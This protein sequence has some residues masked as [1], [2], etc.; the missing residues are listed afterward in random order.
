MEKKSVDFVLK[1]QEILAVENTA[2]EHWISLDK[3]VGDLILDWVDL[4]TPG[5]KIPRVGDVIDTTY[6]QSAEGIFGSIYADLKGVVVYV[7]Q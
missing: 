7:N 4:T 1:I 5:S 6:V 2:G 3:Q